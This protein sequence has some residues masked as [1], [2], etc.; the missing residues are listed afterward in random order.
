MKG[1]LIA[2]LTVGFFLITGMV[3]AQL[4]VGPSLKAGVTY[5]ANRVVDDTSR[6][7][8]QNSPGLYV[9]GGLDVLYQFNDNVRVQAG[10]QYSQKNF[11]LALKSFRSS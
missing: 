4:F 8:L 6:F 2:L 1:K 11:T 9:G 10:I 5:G 7:Y 3:Q